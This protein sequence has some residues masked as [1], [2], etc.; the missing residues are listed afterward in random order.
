VGRDLT[1]CLSAEEAHAIRDYQLTFLRDQAARFEARVR[2]GRVRDG[3][4][5][6]RLEHVYVGPDRDVT[7]LD[8]IEF[9]D[10]F[11]FADVSAD[12]AFLSMDLASHGRVD[13]A[14]RLLARYARE[15]G[16]FDLY[17]VIDFYESYRAFVRGKITLFG[18]RDPDL[19]RETRERVLREARHYF[20]LSLA[21]SRPAL[22]APCV[23]AVGGV[24][25]SGKSTIADRIGGELT[26][27]VIEAD[28]T[29]KD[30][31]GVAATHN[32]REGAWSGAYDPAFTDQVYGE[33]FRRASAV[34]SS[35]RPVVLDASFRSREMRAAARAL[36]D[37]HD[38]PF[39]FVECR[40]PHETCR[41]RLVERAQTTSVS[42]GRLEIFDAFCARFEPVEEFTPAEHVPLDTSRSVDASVA[43]LRERIEC[44]PKSLTA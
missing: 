33:V 12:L 35:G 23:V 41:R 27:A 20:L 17:C 43:V 13:L 19:D 5:D 40:A 26:A 2:H 38:A 42:D 32:L 28:R 15:A 36:A 18:A 37:M 39:L 10:R 7:V 44:W 1:T 3:H 30:M 21:S 14:E 31:L 22:C 24:I 9:N 8:C 4:G 29:R 16:D 34:L 11:R 25:G 6:L